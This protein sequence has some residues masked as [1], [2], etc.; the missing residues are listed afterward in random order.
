MQEFGGG[1]YK[2]LLLRLKDSR[3]IEGSRE[4]CPFPSRSF[5]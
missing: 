1:A 4:Q 3:D 2:C 5:R